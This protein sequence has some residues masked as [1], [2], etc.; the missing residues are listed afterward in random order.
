MSFDN[1][2][3]IELLRPEYA[4]ALRYCRA[5]CAKR[6][7]DD[8]DDVIQQSLLKALE[9]F[10]RLKDHDK[11]RQWL[12]SI[13]TREFYTWIRKD[14]W[15]KYLPSDDSRIFPEPP[16]LINRAEEASISADIKSALGI[17]KHKERAA[18]LL[19]ETGGFSIEEIK[20]IQNERSAS[21][22]KSR[23]SR[24]RKKLREFFENEGAHS[25]TG[26]KQ[27]IQE[28]DLSNETYR[29]IQDGQAG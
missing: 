6:T 22:V 25:S 16:E 9:N 5:L 20:E 4:D 23:L 10:H 2:R 3:F 1:N 13:I 11:F 14:I 27:P 17:L 26:I 15:R 18:I 8:A 21:A 24:A 29:I 19:F 12:F 7:P 28:G